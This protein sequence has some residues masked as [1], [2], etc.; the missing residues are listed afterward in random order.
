MPWVPAPSKHVEQFNKAPWPKAPLSADPLYN[1]TLMTRE[2][3]RTVFLGL[4]AGYQQRRFHQVYTSHGRAGHVDRNTRDTH[5]LSMQSSILVERKV[6]QRMIEMGY[7]ATKFF[8]TR[9][10]LIPTVPLQ[11]L[12]YEKQSK[13][14][15]HADSHVYISKEGRM[16]WEHNTPERKFT[17][18]CWL[19]TY[20]D[21]PNAPNEFNGGQVRFP[22][23]K[24][25]QG[26]PLVIRPYAG[27][28]V[29]FPSHPLYSHEVVPV[30]RGYRMALVQF[31]DT[32]ATD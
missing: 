17:S 18:L 28:I 19:S 26:E 2:E 9:A 27:Q 14:V 5:D 30:V 21:T 7:E 13:F 12:G 22:Y 32:H 20:R 1:D 25:E 23:L 31:F 11:V 4:I 8:G 6:E 10:R 29:F 15:L 3:A 24:N 16:V